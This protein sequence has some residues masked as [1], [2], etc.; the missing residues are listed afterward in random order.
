MD[1]YIAPEGAEFYCEDCKDETMEALADGGGEADCPN[2]CSGCNA[3]LENPLT[4]EGEEYVRNACQRSS[5]DNEVVVEYKERYAYLFGA[6]PEE[7]FDAYVDCALWSSDPGN[8]NGEMVGSFESQ[9]YDVS[10]VDEATLAK[11][12]EDCEAFWDNNP[13]CAIDPECAGHDFWLTRNRHGAGFWDGDWEEG[14]SLTDAAHVYGSVDLY[15]GDDDKIY[16]S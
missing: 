7:F 14:R 13:A 15:L 11:W 4:S 10:D 16:G 2:H 3:F 9:G 12:R 8:E 1:A 6:M 5:E